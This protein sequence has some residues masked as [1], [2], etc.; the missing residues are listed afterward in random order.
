MPRDYWTNGY[1]G[2]VLLIG[3]PAEPGYLRDFC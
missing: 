1:D 3:G 2:G